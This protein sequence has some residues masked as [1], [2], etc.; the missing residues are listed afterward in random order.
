MAS[1]VRLPLNG[2]GVFGRSPSATGS[3]GP[4]LDVGPSVTLHPAVGVTQGLGNAGATW[5]QLGSGLSRGSRR[6]PL[7][8]VH[9][10]NGL[11]LDADLGALV[12]VESGSHYEQTLLGMTLAFPKKRIER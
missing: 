10:T 6:L 5:L 7:L 11:S 4:Q 8:Q 2:E 1:S 3:L 9:L 12:N